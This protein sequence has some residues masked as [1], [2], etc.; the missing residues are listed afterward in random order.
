MADVAAKAKLLD[1]APLCALVLDKDG[2]A[3]V[4][5]KVFVELMGPLY[6]FSGYSFSQAA[7]EDEGKAKLAAAIE[8]VRSGASSRERLRNLQM[9]TL[10]G[11]SGLPVKSYF[12]WFLGASC[13][14]PGEVTLYGDPCS[15]DILEQRHKDAELV[16]FFQ[17]APIALHWLSGTGHVLWANQTE[18]DVLGYT[19][20]EYI[21]QP[22]MKFCPDEEE[23]VLEIFKTLGSGNI[24]KD[25]P[26]RFRTKQGKIVPLLIDSNVAYTTDDKGEKAFGH[27]RCFIR[28]DT[29]RRV[30]DARADAMLQETKRSLKLLDAF[31]SRTLHLVKTPCHVVQAQL[32]VLASN[33]E[34]LSASGLA[35]THQSFVAETDALLESSM[36]QLGHVSALINDASD[37]MRFEQGAILQT[38]PV[39]LP[40]KVLGR[41]VVDEARI[42][43]KPNVSI[44]FEFA[45]GPAVAGLDA[46][47]LHRALDQ[48][49]RNAVEAT[50]KS[51][52]GGRVTLRVSHEAATAVDASAVD[53]SDASGAKGHR[54]R[55]EV[56]DTGCGLPINRGGKAEDVFQRYAPGALPDA[57]ML[58]SPNTDARELQTAVEDAR[59]GLES[60]MSFSASKTTGLG[61]GLNLAYGLVRAMNGELRFE[62]VPG[63]T[64]FWFV[65]PV[66][67]ATT[68]EAAESYC[69]KPA[70][71]EPS[72]RAAL[73][74][75]ALK[76]WDRT[77]RKE[78]SSK[79]S[80]KPDWGSIHG[81]TN[82]GT[83]TSGSKASGSVAGDESPHQTNDV[84]G[85][86]SPLQT[87]GSESNS[88]VKG[89]NSHDYA[90]DASSTVSSDASPLMQGRSSFE[91][92]P[93]CTKKVE[94]HELS[95]QGLKAL[96]PPHVLVVEDTDMCALV[97]TMLLDQ[98][99]CSSDVAENGQE[100]LD[101]L[102][103]S[104]PGLFSLVLMDLRMPVM[105]G[106]EATEGIKAR[107][108]T[109]PVIA[110]TA[111]DTQDARDRCA[112]IGFDDFASKPMHHETLA[113]LL[114]KHTGHKV[115]GR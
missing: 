81:A 30:R 12:D 71:P 47:V 36:H 84:A 79:K 44:T 66:E 64:R 76:L 51:K 108:I 86:E 39:A 88:F 15:D 2:K 27:T 1:A 70:T 87:N 93:S 96:E 25:V 32:G 90:S 49:M 112:K 110:L 31:I 80:K 20:E 14:V 26:V 54:V 102:D 43:A 92:A 77:S 11:E 61:I 34:T 19:A 95:N 111:D 17:N 101:K 75:P 65:L 42:S 5:N 4:V 48:L 73:R 56:H 97:L 100:A 53:A 78:R 10:A 113:S 85:D 46:K 103:A 37:V 24:I 68:P 83:F 105:D 99:G 115:V 98:L 35:K 82:T 114:E 33:V 60:K 59:K 91:E 28:D 13:E 41:A 104:E 3:S 45:A 62:S 109:A 72:T 6:K 106:F 16:D 57:S 9:I 107:G 52:D 23:L 7:A 8:A 50:S 38:V 69:P 21:G 63:N 89:R 74:T 58:S 22:I 67:G 29:G 40:I 94:A 55:F 18:L